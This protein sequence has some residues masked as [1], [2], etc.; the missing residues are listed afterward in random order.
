MTFTHTLSA[1]ET[2]KERKSEKER[3][4]ARETRFFAEAKQRKSAAEDTK[5]FIFSTSI[6]YTSAAEAAA[7]A[8]TNYNKSTYMNIN[9]NIR[10]IYIVL[11]IRDP[12]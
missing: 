8:A 9:I 5:H 4:N 11:S 6:R 7:A 10:N 1:L 2:E 3:E 12:S